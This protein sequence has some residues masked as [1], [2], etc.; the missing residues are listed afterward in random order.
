VCYP[1]EYCG[2]DQDRVPDDDPD[3]LLRCVSFKSDSC[4]FWPGR[5]IPERLVLRQRSPRTALLSSS[6]P[7]T[8]SLHQPLTILSSSSLSV[9]RAS[10]S[11]RGA[12]WS[13]SVED[14]DEEGE[15][16]GSGEY[17]EFVK[18]GS[19]WVVRRRIFRVNWVI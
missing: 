1:A 9:L 16:E 11:L 19:F 18:V 17:M 10:V 14:E 13:D 4:R 7:M 6:A 5:R 2:N 15:E 12:G 3:R 8:T